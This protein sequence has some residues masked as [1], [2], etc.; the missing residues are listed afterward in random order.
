MSRLFHKVQIV[1]YYELVAVGTALE[2]DSSMAIAGS[3]LATTISDDSY[4][5][6]Y[7]MNNIFAHTC[8]II[9]FAIYFHQNGHL[10]QRLYALYRDDEE[11]R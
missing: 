5:N 9:L 11:N 8:F 10:I 1:S 6:E 3:T 4:I 2:G 7:T